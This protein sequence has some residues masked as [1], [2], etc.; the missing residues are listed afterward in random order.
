V[1]RLAP[2]F[3]LV[4][5]GIIAFRLQTGSEP[6]GSVITLRYLA[7]IACGLAILASTEDSFK[8]LRPRLL[9]IFTLSL[10][11]LM[12]VFYHF[13]NY[14]NVDWDGN[15]TYLL[16]IKMIVGKYNQF[17]LWD[18]YLCGGRPLVSYSFPMYP[19]LLF[20]ITLV[21]PIFEAMKVNLLLYVIIGFAGGYALGSHLRLNPIS[22]LY[23]GTVFV[24]SGAFGARIAV[25]HYC[26][27]SP[28]LIPWIV[29]F[30]MK[31]TDRLR[32]GVPC[33]ITLLFFAGISHVFP[34]A[35]TL[36]FI[37]F[38]TVITFIIRF[39]DRLRGK[40]NDVRWVIRPIM[41][42]LIIGCLSFM[43][44]SFRLVPMLEFFKDHRYIHDADGW[45]SLIKLFDVYEV[46]AD[47]HIAYA[48]HEQ[49]GFVGVLAVLL[50]LYGLWVSWRQRT[51]LP[52]VVFLL[53]CV[54]FSMGHKGVVDL[55][56]FLHNYPP[57]ESLR[58]PSRTVLALTFVVAVFSARG[59]SDIE[60]H[61]SG[62][63]KFALFFTLFLL[64]Y[65]NQG[66]LDGAFPYPP[67]R[68]Q[69]PDTPGF[70]SIL[71]T[72]PAN[73]TGAVSWMYGIVAQDTGVSN[74]YVD[75]G[76]VRWARSYSELGY[77]GEVYL[78]EGR[79][80][81]TLTSFSPN[82][83]EIAVNAT[84]DDVLIVNQNYFPGWKVV[85][86]GTTAD[87]EGLISTNVTRDTASLTLYYL[88][89]SFLVGGMMTVIGIAIC[90]CV[91]I[92]HGPSM[93]R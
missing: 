24:F 78:L 23:L 81:A 90:V 31:A 75:P 34:I 65:S 14:G 72:I 7:L 22:R 48:W 10:A 1:S 83:L 26:F 15:A 42:L 43:L 61:G 79:G 28:Y 41:A 29:L 76:P 57:F 11:F 17:P 12:P 58:M 52:F 33:A 71:Y 82:R 30:T 38:Y 54:V 74:C 39:A 40:T 16:I 77:R 73:H 37:V 2:L 84:G 88:P 80:N 51:Y 32:Y 56:G 9:L 35:L 64:F 93:I 5:L 85:G 53:F 69:V 92:K 45:H 62:F 4:A 21:L 67:H 6:F 66:Y 25:G 44:F 27:F 36:V 91:L 8:S 49:N 68:I 3:V 18:P 89:D 63:P 19:D 50:A 55:W 70:K 86:G 13:E 87:S 46:L 20:P 59:L 47:V 60:R